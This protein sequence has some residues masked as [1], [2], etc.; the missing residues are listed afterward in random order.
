LLTGAFGYYGVFLSQK[1]VHEIGSVR[2][3]GVENLSLPRRRKTF[4]ATS[5]LSLA[6]LDETTR[7]RQYADIQ[8]AQFVLA[9]FLGRINR[10]GALLPPKREKSFRSPV[11]LNAYKYRV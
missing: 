9:V 11:L 7:S 10:R 5:T 8:A 1:A 2:L 6:G 4:A 3:P